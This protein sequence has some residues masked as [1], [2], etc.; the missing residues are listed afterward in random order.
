[1][2]VD[3]EHDRFDSTAYLGLYGNGC[4]MSI[5]MFMMFV[6]LMYDRFNN[7]VCGL[8]ELAIPGNLLTD[9]FKVTIHSYPAYPADTC[10]LGGREI[11]REELKDLLKFSL[12]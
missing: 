7:A 4:I 10:D 2:P 8:L 6:P 12:G 11:F 3:P 5:A 1:M 9:F